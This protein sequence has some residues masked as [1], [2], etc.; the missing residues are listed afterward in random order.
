MKLAAWTQSLT[1]QAPAHV[2]ENLP[3]I[4]EHR[5]LKLQTCVR[6]VARCTELL[7]RK[8]ATSFVFNTGSTYLK[9]NRP[10]VDQKAF[11]PLS[12]VRSMTSKFYTDRMPHPPSHKRATAL[13]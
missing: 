6:H 4:A 7:I 13:S 2:P 10:R 1:I 3:F 5:D 11:H 12:A 9:V 8:H